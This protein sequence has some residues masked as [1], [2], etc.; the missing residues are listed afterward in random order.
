[1]PGKV[2][3]AS[4]TSSSPVLWE[5][6]NVGTNIVTLIAVNRATKRLAR[7]A[8]S[9]AACSSAS[10]H[11][12]TSGGLTWRTVSVGRTKSVL[13]LEAKVSRKRSI[14]ISVLLIILCSM[15]CC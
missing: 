1:M 14:V 4:S 9:S 6:R 12:D 11:L 8:Y 7:L 15:I 5:V 2:S 13:R 10:V 3:F